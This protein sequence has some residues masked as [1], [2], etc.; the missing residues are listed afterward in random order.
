MC[1]QDLLPSFVWGEIDLQGNE[2]LMVVLW[3]YHSLEQS[4]C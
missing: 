3:Q 1:I 4:L 2:E